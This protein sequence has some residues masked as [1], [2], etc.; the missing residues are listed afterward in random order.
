MALQYDKN[1]SYDDA[2]KYDHDE[3]PF[4]PAFPDDLVLRDL[5]IAGANI[6]PNQ[7][8]YPFAQNYLGIKALLVADQ[9]GH[10]SRLEEESDTDD[11]L[12]HPMDSMGNLILSE[13]R[14]GT[15]RK[16]RL[17]G[18][19]VVFD[20]VPN[21]SRTKGIRIL[22]NRQS[23]RFTFQDTTKELGIPR[24]FHDW[25]CWKAALPYLIK[26]RLPNKNDIAAQ[27]AAKE[28]PMNPLSIPRFLSNRNQARKGRIR[29]RQ[30][31]NR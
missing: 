19:S 28:N 31:S 10:F 6:N 24:A 2:N 17:V 25:A 27:I 3:S 26:N 16:Y 29:V 4:A 30:E 8:D 18:N 11:C 12:S 14:F 5:N 23:S 9:N 15:P 21:Y 22:V 13:C 7:V 20:V 1:W